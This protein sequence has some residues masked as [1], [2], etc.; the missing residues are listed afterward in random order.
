DRSDERGGAEDG[1]G[2]RRTDLLLA[3]A[4]ERPSQ[5]EVDDPGAGEEQ[6]G[7]RRPDLEGR[8]VPGEQGEERHRRRPD[9]QQEERGAV[10]VHRLVGP[11]VDRLEQPE[12]DPCARREHDSAHHHTASD[13]AWLAL[14][15]KGTILQTIA[16]WSSRTADCPTRRERGVRSRCPT[17]NSP[18]R[19]GGW[20]PEEWDSLWP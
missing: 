20:E 13:P 9:Q 7:A 19:S 1:P 11:A 4:Q 8:Q 6:E 15:K 14:E 2:S 17:R 12:T 18:T 3:E 10:G 5:E 16:G